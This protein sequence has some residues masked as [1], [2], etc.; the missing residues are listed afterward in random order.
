M[1]TLK[2]LHDC[3]GNLIHQYNRPEYNSPYYFEVYKCDKCEEIVSHFV[4]RDDV[5]NGQMTFM[6]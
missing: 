6:Q 5:E 3:G 4:K 1:E 2:V